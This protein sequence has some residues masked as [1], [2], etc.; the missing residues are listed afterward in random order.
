M[1]P[2]H[3][4]KKVDQENVVQ[5]RQEIDFGTIR[6][7]RWSMIQSII[8]IMRNDLA[9]VQTILDYRFSEFENLEL[10]LTAAGADEANHNGNRRMA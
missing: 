9:Q 6:N 10:A 3:A 8:M 2:F 7:N 1:L 5:L 4:W